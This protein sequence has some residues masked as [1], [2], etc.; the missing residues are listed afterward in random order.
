MTRDDVR[1]LL[2]RI[3]HTYGRRMKITEELV[4]S[5]RQSLLHATPEMANAALDRWATITDGSRPPNLAQLCGIVGRMHAALASEPTEP[6]EPF[7]VCAARGIRAIEEIRARRAPV[8][9]RWIRR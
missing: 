5:W 3:A 4:E 2:G 8:D 9:A 6:E 1:A 7:E